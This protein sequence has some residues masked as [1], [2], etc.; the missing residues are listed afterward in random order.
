MKDRVKDRVVHI[1]S[2]Y[3]SEL[4]RSDESDQSVLTQDELERASRFVFD[5]DREKYILGRSYLR[6]LLSS[7][8][9]VPF[10]DVAFDYN[11]QGKPTLGG[12]NSQRLLFNV[13]HAEDAL[14]IAVLPLDPIDSYDTVTEP[15]LLGV[16]IES[17]DRHIPF[18]E[19][20]KSHFSDQEILKLSFY[21]DPRIPFYRCWTRKEAYIKAHGLGVSYGLDVFGVSLDESD[22]TRV[23]FDSTTEASKWEIHSW[24]L[25]DD[26]FGALALNFAGARLEHRLFSDL[27]LNA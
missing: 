2:G 10:E 14:C 26:Y 23:E 8:L 12:D 7:Y 15:Q 21:S 5:R 17:I 11:S 13:S 9:N 20:A 1:W 22:I 3:F 4:S 25:G 24:R 18:H 16:D 19:V 27:V 6:R